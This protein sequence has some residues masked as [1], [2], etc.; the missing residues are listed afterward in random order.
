[1]EWLVSDICPADWDS[2]ACQGKGI[3]MILGHQDLIHLLGIYC[4]VNVVFWEE[5][6]HLYQKAGKVVSLE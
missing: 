5:L 1:M 2:C 3:S 6:Q 4:W